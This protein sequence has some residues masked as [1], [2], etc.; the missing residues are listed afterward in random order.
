MVDE[1]KLRVV[2]GAVNIDQ[3]NPRNLME[4][5]RGRRNLPMDIPIAGLVLRLREDRGVHWFLDTV[6]LVLEKRPEA[7]FIFVGRGEMKYWL[8][9]YVRKCPHGE[10]LILAGYY[11]Q[12]LEKMYALFD[13]TLFLGLGSDGSSRAVLE[14]MA[15]GKPVIGI[16]DGGLDEVIIPGENG[17]LVPKNDREKLAEAIL[18][19]FE[20]RE[21]TKQMGINARRLMEERFTEEKRADDTLALY[22]EYMKKVLS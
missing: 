10:N 2:Y 21:K 13:C 9:D 12:D 17:L 14:A 4:V 7:R 5:E 11:K 8:H 22:H 19:L 15:S 16:N 1:S 18:T 6:P 20:D 3:F